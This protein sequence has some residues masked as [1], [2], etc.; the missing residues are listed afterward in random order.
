MVIVVVLVIVLIFV[1]LLLWGLSRARS[2]RAGQTASTE[3]DGRGSNRIV[4]V[5][6]TFVT[7]G[8]G[9][10]LPLLILH[11]NDANTSKQVG[12]VK[13]TA[14]SKSGRLLFGQH[15][16]VCHTLSAANAI[17]KVGPDLDELKPP[18]AEVLHVI[19]NGCLPNVTVKDE[20]EACLGQGVMPAEV[21]SGQ[22][23]QDVASFVAQAAGH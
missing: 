19:A 17:G 11:G 16:A 22:D 6:F 2:S 3:V 23:A 10:A 21:V 12:G 5:V 20:N 15:C 9:I 8:F 4:A 18:K 13:L 7:L 1:P 14:D